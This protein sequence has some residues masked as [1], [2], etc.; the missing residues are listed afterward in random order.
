MAKR[1]GKFEIS[2]RN[3]ALVGEANASISRAFKQVAPKI[4]RAIKRITPVDTGRL[5]K[6]VGVRAIR[7]R[8]ARI[9]IATVFYGRFVEFGTV[10]MAPQPFIFPVVIGQKEKW[11]KEV[12][13]ASRRDLRAR[14]RKH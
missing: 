14:A 1:W 12:L 10:K 3:I 6:S 11:R 8:D 7:G 13:R 2:F 4:E 5:K 9:D